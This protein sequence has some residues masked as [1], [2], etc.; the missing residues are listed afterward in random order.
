MGK[1]RKP[2]QQCCFS[3]RQPSARQAARFHFSSILPLPFLLEARRRPWWNINS[4]V[5]ERLFITIIAFGSFDSS[6]LIRLQGVINVMESAQAG[7]GRGWGR[8]SSRRS[9][10]AGRSHR[11]QP[12]L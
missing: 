5:A 2:L 6:L 8:C 10:Y 3:S 7:F 11:S 12:E 1:G 9:S 4:V